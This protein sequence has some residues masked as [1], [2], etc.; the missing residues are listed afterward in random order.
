MQF[1]WMHPGSLSLLCL[2][3]L[4]VNNTFSLHLE[5]LTNSDYIFLTQ[6]LDETSYY[7]ASS[8]ATKA[9]WHHSKPVYTD[10]S[11]CQE[12]DTLSQGWWVRSVWA[13]DTIVSSKLSYRL[14]FSLIRYPECLS[15]YYCQGSS[16]LHLVA[17]TLTRWAARENTHT[18]MH[19]VSKS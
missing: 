15:G 7:W 8:T 3:Y 13:S 6:T 1:I 16:I 9:D 4:Y 17:S 18:H 10:S 19:S 11:E 2:C 12:D 5:M 14:C